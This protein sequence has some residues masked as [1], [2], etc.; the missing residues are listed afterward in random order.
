MQ[1]SVLKLS[2]SRHKN[3]KDLI[4]LNIPVNELDQLTFI[5]HSTQQ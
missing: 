4:D 5:E 2:V 3:F 1:I